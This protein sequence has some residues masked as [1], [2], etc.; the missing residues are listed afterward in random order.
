MWKKRRVTGN[1]GTPPR[2]RAEVNRQAVPSVWMDDMTLWNKKGVLPNPEERIPHIRGP[3][4]EKPSR[5]TAESTKSP[6]APSVIHPRDSKLDQ[7]SERPHQRCRTSFPRT[8]SSNFTTKL[9]EKPEN[10]PYV[11]PPPCKLPLVLWTQEGK[12]CGKAKRHGRPNRT[13]D[14]CAVPR[15]DLRA[16][17]TSSFLKLLLPLRSIRRKNSH[18]FS[19]VSK[20]TMHYVDCLVISSGIRLPRSSQCSMML[21]VQ[22]VIYE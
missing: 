5:T 15:G 4:E 7:G 3:H 10:E 20:R 12:K 17:C 14:R 22:Q 9:T 2:P 18:L 21:Q 6:A 19:R 8:V 16:K 13:L 11:F 1:Q